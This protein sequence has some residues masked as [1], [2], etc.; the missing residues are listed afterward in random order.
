MNHIAQY[1]RLGGIRPFLE[2]FLYESLVIGYPSAPMEQEAIAMEHK[3]CWPGPSRDLWERAMPHI[4]AAGR[5]AG[6]LKR[7]R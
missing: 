2:C 5:A 1:E 7:S 6:S 3:V 4:D